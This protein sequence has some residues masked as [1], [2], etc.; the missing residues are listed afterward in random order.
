MKEFYAKKDKLFKFAYFYNF[1]KHFKQMKTRTLKIVPFFMNLKTVGRVMK[2]TMDFHK[3]ALTVGQYLVWNQKKNQYLR[4]C[5]SIQ[6]DYYLLELFSKLEKLEPLQQNAQQWNE[7]TANKKAFIDN[8]KFIPCLTFI[9]RM[10]DDVRQF[11]LVKN[12]MIRKRTA[13]STK[14]LTDAQ[15]RSK[16]GQRKQHECMAGDDKGKEEKKKAKDMTNEGALQSPVGN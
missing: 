3:Q 12:W 14:N 13:Q 7:T 1:A 5:L 8:K 2:Q 15:K 11:L 16:K 4:Y 9:R 6:W 10:G